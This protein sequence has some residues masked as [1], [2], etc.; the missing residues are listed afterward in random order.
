MDIEQLK[1]PIGKYTPPEIITPAHLAEWIATI[2]SLPKLL[3]DAVEGLTDVQLDTPYR[4]DGWTVRQVVHHLADSHMNAF[5]RFKLTVTED[6]PTIKPY[7]E[8]RWAQLADSTMPVDVSLELLKSLHARWVILLQSLS[9]VEFERTYFHP[10]YQYTV[11]LARVTGL[12]AWHSNHH[13]RHITALK[14]RNN[15]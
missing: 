8:E 11:P 9:S 15:W 6:N 5:I 13:L 12:Y 10:Q 2:A 1:Y 4:P 14:E 7:F 3:A